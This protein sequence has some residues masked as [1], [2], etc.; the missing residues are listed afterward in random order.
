MSSNGSRSAHHGETH[1]IRDRIIELVRV[2][3][4]ELVDNPANWRRHPEHQRTALR[5]VLREIGSRSLPG[6][7]TGSSLWLGAV[8]PRS[9]DRR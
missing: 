9:P 1:P 8:A 5:G 7:G 6:D 4:S 3:A 2:R